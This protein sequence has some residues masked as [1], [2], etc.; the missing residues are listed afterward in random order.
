MPSLNTDMSKVVSG[1]SKSRY[2]AT[3]DGWLLALVRDAYEVLRATGKNTAKHP[4]CLPE[5][6]ATRVVHRS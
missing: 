1:P 2:I 4:R 5:Y 6:R 3:R